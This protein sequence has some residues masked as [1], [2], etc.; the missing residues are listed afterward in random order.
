[1]AQ[2]IGSVI[3]GRAPWRAERVFRG[4]VSVGV[5]MAVEAGVV[6]GRAPRGARGVGGR[7]SVG[8]GMVVVRHATARVVVG[9]PTWRAER[10]FDG[11]ASVGVGMV[12]VRHATTGVFG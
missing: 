7:A 6:V 12:V 1:M 4:R 2:A 5:G 8:V 11:R 9:R 3:G 10:V